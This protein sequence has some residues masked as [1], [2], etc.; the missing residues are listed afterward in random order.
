MSARAR[1]AALGRVVRSGV[2]RRRVQTL[3]MMLTTII[4]AAASV[5]AA[6]VLV[7]SQAPFDHAFAAQHGAHLTAQF[8]R[9]K[10]TAAQLAATAHAPGVTAAAGPFPTASLHPVAGGHGRC[11]PVCRSAS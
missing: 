7:D 2:G 3:V 8:N 5:L 1:R 9:S 10:V 4:A 11:P 6:G